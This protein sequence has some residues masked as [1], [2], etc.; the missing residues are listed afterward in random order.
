MDKVFSVIQVVLPIFCCVFIGIY[1][2]KKGLFS[3][4]E[5]QAFQRFVVK[6]CLPCLLFKSCLTAEIGMQALSSLVLPVILLFTAIWGFKVGRKWFPH[7]NIPFV[8]CCKET[9]MLGIPLFMILFGADQAY[10]VG[11]LD[12]TQ[13]IVVFPV[14]AILSAA[15]GTAAS[16]KAVIKEMCRSPLIL[17]SLAGITLNLSGA[18]DWLQGAGVGGILTDT[19]SY[20]AQP[21]SV[22]MLFCVGYNFSLEGENGTEIFRIAGVHSL[23]FLGVGLLMQG[24]LCFFPGVDAL[25]RWAVLL[26]TFLPIS[27]MVPSLGRKEDDFVV[28]S[29]VCS[30]LTVVTLIVFCI[31][32]VI[33][34]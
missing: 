22:L 5:I 20:I 30:V 3:S 8:F 21:V 25:T 33:V 9:G 12:V 16:P 23:M 15:P 34:S 2:K 28:A 27:F 10:R 6:F 32:A 31:M 13:A 17:M 7:H 11:I 19:V 1:S 24:A 29:G 18:W 4:D 14:I 26:Y